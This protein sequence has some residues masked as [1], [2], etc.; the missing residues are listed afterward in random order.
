MLISV[1]S[2]LE[3]LESQ[4][5]GFIINPDIG[6]NIIFAKSFSQ[7]SSLRRSIIKLLIDE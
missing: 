5:Q 1:A 7:S 3:K 6:V 2:Q 4:Q